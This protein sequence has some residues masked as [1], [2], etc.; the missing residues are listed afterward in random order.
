MLG[1]SLCLEPEM[2][3]TEP[4]S[5]RSLAGEGHL[6]AEEGGQRWKKDAEGGRDKL[7]VQEVCEV[8]RE[9]RVASVLVGG[10]WSAPETL[11]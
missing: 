11:N 1:V 5:H 7:E 3:G 9:T 2:G 10:G 6:R 4:G 8:T